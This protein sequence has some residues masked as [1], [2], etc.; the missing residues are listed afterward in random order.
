MALIARQPFDPNFG[1]FGGE[2]AETYDPGVNMG[3][4]LSDAWKFATKNPLA[5]IAPPVYLFQQTIPL[6]HAA[7]NPTPQNLAPF[8]NTPLA[9]AAGGGV[10]PISAAQTLTPPTPAPSMLPIFLG[11]GAAALLLILAFGR[12]KK[13]HES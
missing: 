13:E 3:N 8:V 2:L 12:K 9:L 10:A 5:I 6:L 4:F 11:A 1:A 7:A